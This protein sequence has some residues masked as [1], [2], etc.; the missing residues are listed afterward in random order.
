MDDHITAR[1][2]PMAPSGDAQ[3]PRPLLT[4]L[5]E[6]NTHPAAG[7]EP[8]P[9]GPPG[10]R[11]VTPARAPTPACRL[12]PASLPDERGDLDDSYPVHPAPPRDP[13]GGP[14]AAPRPPCGPS[15]TIRS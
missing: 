13:V 12:S 9:S 2:H 4:C 6:G 7:Q 10:A 3:A 5:G 11:P 8:L 15:T 1:F 14:L